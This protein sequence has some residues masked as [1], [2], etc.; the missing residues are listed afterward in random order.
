MHRATAT[1]GNRRDEAFVSN[2]RTTSVLVRA[3]GCDAWTSL[4]W[5]ARSEGDAPVDPALVRAQRLR[6]VRNLD[7]DQL[8]PQIRDVRPLPQLRD[9]FSEKKVRNEVRRQIFV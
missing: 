5:C 3:G 8:Q 6:D 7:R 2:A 1:P 4:I 9:H